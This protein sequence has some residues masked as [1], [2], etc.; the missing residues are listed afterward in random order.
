[1]SRTHRDN[2]RRLDR[3]VQREVDRHQLR[4]EDYLWRWVPRR[5]VNRKVAAWWSWKW[6]KAQRYKVDPRELGRI[7]II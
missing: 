2:L 6:H 3:K 7:G 1:M 4:R 5:G